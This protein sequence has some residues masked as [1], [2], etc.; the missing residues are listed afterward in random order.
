MLNNSNIENCPGCILLKSK[1]LVS[2]WLNCPSDAMGY[3]PNILSFQ[4]KSENCPMKEVV[5]E[6][7]LCNVRPTV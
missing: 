5:M 4:H 7:I 2:Q 6:D 3:S 1:T